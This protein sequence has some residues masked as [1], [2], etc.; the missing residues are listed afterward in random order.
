[1]DDS[2]QNNNSTHANILQRKEQKLS[3]TKTWVKKNSQCPLLHD[4]YHLSCNEKTLE[5]RY[6][7]HSRMLS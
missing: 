3:P 2:E 4:T 6:L 7:P 5:C 1:M